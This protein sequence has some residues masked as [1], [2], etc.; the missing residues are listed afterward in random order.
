MKPLIDELWDRGEYSEHGLRMNFEDVAPKKSTQ[1][2]ALSPEIA[3][4]AENLVRSK[5]FAFPP[6]DD[7]HMPYEHTAIEYDLT[8][9][10]K[11][12]R[13]NGLQG[14]ESICRVGAYVREI[15]NPHSFLCT[16]YWQFSDG[17]VQSSVL[18]FVYGIDTPPGMGVV[19]LS[20]NKQGRGAIDVAVMPNRAMV[21][22]L[23]RANVSPEYF[24][25]VSR[26]EQMLIHTRES[27]VEVPLLLF[28][29]SM[30]LNCRSGMAKA[31]VDART[32]N[33]SGLGEKKRKKLSSSAYTLV[34]LLALEDVSPTGEV[35]SRVGTAAHFVRG[36]FKQRKS[37]VY[38]WNSF[39]RGTGEPRKRI[40]YNVEA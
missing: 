3:L 39:V 13:D 33:Q 40:A 32:P 12:L 20:P 38:W 9:E 26:T 15:K 17:R 35:T 16:P 10:V 31:R 4:A 28:A 27:A 29:C 25:E 19:S 1:I 34:H 2:F 7:M 23:V 21:K 37:G 24:A 11:A 6:V 22:G 30:L 36:H 5:A 18:S 8:P 14:S